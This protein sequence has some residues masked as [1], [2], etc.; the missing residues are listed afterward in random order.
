M[1]GSLADEHQALSRIVTASGTKE[2]RVYWASD[3]SDNSGWW[4]PLYLVFVY[5]ANRFEAES[6][7]FVSA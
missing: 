6:A 2:E 1:R 3:T 4:F 5:F 7:K